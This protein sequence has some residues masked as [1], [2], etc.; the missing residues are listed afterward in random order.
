MMRSN[1]FNQPDKIVKRALEL[2]RIPNTNPRE[3]GAGRGV[4]ATHEDMATTA[5]DD[6]YTLHGFIL[7]LDELDDPHALLG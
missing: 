1:P 2:A 3:S 6:G 4:F 7:D 5:D